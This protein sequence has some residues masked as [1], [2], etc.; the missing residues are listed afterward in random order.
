VDVFRDLPRSEV[1][2]LAE[3]CPIVR[4]GEKEGLAPL[5]ERRGVLLL[6]GGRVR[7]H[8][9]ALGTQGLTFSVT[10]SATLVA[11]TGPER[12]SSRAL[13]VEALEPS[14]LSLVGW[15]DFEELVSR[16]P[17][18][19]LETIRLLGKRLDVYEGRLVDQV[20]KEVPAR[21]AGLL[22]GLSEREGPLSK[23]SAGSP[24]ATPASSWRAW[25]GP[26]A[27]R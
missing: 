18:V 26:T 24:L 19:G 20:R 25:W 16:N 14:I 15:E 17:Q 21:L 27:K 1:E 9:Q 8:E 3:R 4:L 6:L 7:V 22:L 5:E 23:A 12:R 13:R 10:E 2:Y 11:Q